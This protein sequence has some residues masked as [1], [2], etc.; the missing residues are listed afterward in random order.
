MSLPLLKTKLYIPPVRP[1]L[2]PR[3]SLIQR[4][5][6]GLHRKL[7]LV[8]APAGSG[9]TTLVSTWLHSGDRP[10]TWLSLDA[11]DNDPI[12]FFTYLIAALQKRDGDIGQSVQ[13]LLEA[14]QSP[15]PES[16]IM[17]LIN[18]IVATPES[19]VLVLDDYHT[20][21]ELA[22]HEAVGLLLERQPL[23]MHL[24]VATRHDPPLP[25]SRLRGRGQ[26]TE[27]RRGD[28][29]F[30][31]EETAAF[32]NQAMGLRL[33]S[34]EIATL[35]ARTEG[36]I[37]GL[38]LAALSMQGR[39]G[40]S[41]A[42]FIEGF[43]GRYHFV[44]DYLTDE[45]LKRQPEPVQRF[46]LQTSI[47][48]QMC[49]P[50][51]DAVLSIGE[52]GLESGDTPVPNSW[53]PSKQMLE[54]LDA[55]NLFI[56]PLDDEHTWYRYHHL[57][58]EL[59]QARLQETDP[60]R[61]PELH[62]Q[63]VGWYEANAFASEA[64]H[65][66]LA[67]E[68][69]GLAADVIQRQIMK[70]ATWSRLDVATLLGWLRALPDEVVH[71]RPWL[72]LF[73][74]RAL[75]STGQIQTTLRILDEL[76]A[77]LRADPSIPDGEQVRQ[78][79]IADRASYAAVRGDVQQ[80]IA[81][82]QRFLARVPEDD[83]FGR[84]RA[85]AILGMAH[86]RS[87]AVS[88]AHHAF[89][90]ASNLAQA[91]DISFVAV[92]MVCNLAEVQIVQG[93]LRQALQTCERAMRI[94]TV[95][96]T[97]I[98]SAGFV[99]LGFGKVLYEQNDL[100]AAERYLLQ[101]LEVLSRGGIAEHFGNMH[102]VLAQV[103][104]AQ[105][106]AESAMAA[107]QQAV[108]MAQGSSIPRL[109][110]LASA[111]QARIWLALGNVDEA[112]QWARDYRQAGET[113]YLREFED[114]TL[115][116]VLLTGNE[117]DEALALLDSLLSS[118]EAAGRQ[119]GV[120]EIQ[121]L[122]ALALQALGKQDEAL[123]TLASTLALAE[124]EGYVRVFVDSGEPMRVLLKQAASHGVAPGYVA[125][126]LAVFD[127]P[128][129]DRAGGPGTHVPSQPLVEPLT[130]REVEVLQLLAKGLSNREISQRLFISLPT[131]KSHTGNI[132][133]KLGV[134][135]RKEAVARATA[136]GMLPSA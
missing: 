136:L 35:E 77:S 127:G 88:Q 3:P 115:A 39:D 111:Y 80:A 30:T 1:E 104:Q 69:F 46:L 62:R 134:H 54:Q 130:D 27:I 40:E 34:T 57:F 132:Y 94:G 86:M 53:H 126:L 2:V 107:I 85:M 18:D 12:R 11:G 117:V 90:T 24:V 45:V 41:V 102:A 87:G 78:L 96:G 51:C 122:R 68:D 91:S 93:R 37:T 125:R 131:V 56:V 28:L 72:W 81:F 124:P 42:R 83:A 97:R 63:A 95:D 29:R 49:S 55:A 66:A 36:W 79:I 17:A 22:I 65:H 129:G 98:S 92:P 123:D 133:G 38:Q 7:T 4:L 61:I 10:S 6:A 135:S 25:L 106:E 113:E 120:I 112:I 26:V 21:A 16:L 109:C 50:L 15:R 73:T 59:L 105:G 114:V 33:T 8:S 44:L 31:R 116:R 100:Q 48:E 84:I 14:S 60:D 74:A 32:L 99:G 19:F 43:S 70:I 58:A 82:A 128:A 101:G 119:G 47:L 110:I 76:E 71:S 9:K 52:R 13:H 23:Q 67:T 121:A 64:V 103:K 118:A 89:T 5:N 20:I 75:F 108:D